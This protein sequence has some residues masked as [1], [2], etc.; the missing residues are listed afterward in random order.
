[1][2]L[3]FPTYRQIIHYL[4]GAVATHPRI[5]EPGIYYPVQR[6][7][8]PLEEITIQR[9]RTYD[10]IELQEPGL[11]CD[12][13]PYY[14][15]RGYKTSIAARTGG[16]SAQFRPYTMGTGSGNSDEGL[17]HIIVQLQYQDL[18][19]NEQT[20]LTIDELYH[21]EGM[22]S[23]HGE[24][25]SLR[26]I[27]EF[28]LD[29]DLTKLNKSLDPLVSL[30]ENKITIEIN[31]AEEILREYLDLLR[32]VLNDCTKMLPFAIRSSQ[33]K[34]FDFPTSSWSRNNEDVY[35]HFA[36]LLLEVCLYPPTTWRDIYFMPVTSATINI[37]NSRH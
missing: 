1:M 31:P 12:I 26:E 13:Y 28:E 19:I 14:S 16:K 22:T 3:V 24:N 6:G 27:S 25:V 10:G 17:Y 32:L 34:E 11:T 8:Q 37:N 29:T 30:R 23:T 15:G 2:N 35:F 21:P 36:W 4:L 33:V 20:V 7:N 5:K 18:A 9:Y